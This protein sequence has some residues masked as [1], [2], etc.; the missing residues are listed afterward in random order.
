MFWPPKVEKTT[1]KSCSEFLKSTFFPYC[2]G[3]SAQMA[4]TEEFMFQ[5]VAYWPT[6]YRSG[7][8][9]ETWWGVLLLKDPE[10][11]R[12][13]I[14]QQENGGKKEDFRHQINHASWDRWNLLSFF[15]SY[16]VIIRSNRIRGGG[17]GKFSNIK[18][19]KLSNHASWDKWDQQRFF[20]SSSKIS[21]YR[22]IILQENGGSY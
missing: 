17:K 4:Q 1:F 9:D 12:E 18:L 22:V 3:Q 10:L 14:V 7:Y 13:N 5:N 2:Q 21:R 16:C 19:I 6:V 8:V 11:S 20:D 15:H